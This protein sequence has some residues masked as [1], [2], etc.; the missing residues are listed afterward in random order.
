M[1]KR[2]S[3]FARWGAFYISLVILIIALAND[4]NFKLIGL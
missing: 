2:E 4:H 1:S 3:H